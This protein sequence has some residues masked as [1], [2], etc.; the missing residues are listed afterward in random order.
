[1]TGDYLAR[2]ALDHFP[3]RHPAARLAR[4]TLC[5]DLLAPWLLRDALDEEIALDQ[6][7]EIG[8]EYLICTQTLYYTGRVRRAGF[9]WIELEHASW[10]HWTGRLSVLLRQRAFTGAAFGTRKPRTEYVGHV[11]IAAGS[12]VS[13]Y[14]PP[15]TLPT[16]PLE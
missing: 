10:I 6:P 3:A 14:G 15:W 2:H 7:F 16:E 5:G 4:A 1:M 12:I 8:K 11:L 9:A 13:A